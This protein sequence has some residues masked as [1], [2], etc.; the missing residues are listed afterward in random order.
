MEIVDSIESRV[1]EEEAKSVQ[2]KLNKKAIATSK[3]SQL[4]TAACRK[5]T[6]KRKFKFFSANLEVRNENFQHDCLLESLFWSRNSSNFISGI[7]YTEQWQL[8]LHGNT[9]SL[10]RQLCFSADKS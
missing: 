9:L 7:Y 3:N 6:K 4:E 1:T 2:E 5:M 10:V 8:M